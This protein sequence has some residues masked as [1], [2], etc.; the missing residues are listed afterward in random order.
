MNENISSF[1]FTGDGKEVKKIVLSDAGSSCAI[2]TYG[3]TLQSFIVPTAKGN[4]DIIVGSN[5]F[6]SFEDAPSYM[7]QVVAP[8]ANRIKDAA[9]NLDGKRYQL[10][11]ND[12]SACLHSGVANTGNKVWEILHV[13]GKSVTLGCDSRDGDGGF[14]GNQ[15][16]EVEYALSS[17]SLAISYHVISDA[18]CPVNVTNH[19][20][21]NLNGNKSD[22]RHHQLMIPS[23]H[24]I[25]VDDELIP[26]VVAPVSGTAFDFT[27][28]KEIGSDRDGK[29]DNCFILDSKGPI[30]ASNGPLTMEV[31]TTM[32][33]VQLYTGEFFSVPNGKWGD[34]AA[35]EGFA[36]E[37]EYYPN[38]VNRADFKGAMVSPGKPWFSKTVYRVR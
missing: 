28:A 22:I 24:Y 34:C 3:A 12:H 21:F 13:E 9:F 8:V 16:F 25:D 15:H 10:T 36:L 30:V 29:Y 17:S 4:L 14:P 6:A 1:G 11:Q 19:A 18:L 37:T 35:F 38:A 23:L 5:L 33:A 7:G 32:P 27:H 31:E 26:T 2:I 20:Y